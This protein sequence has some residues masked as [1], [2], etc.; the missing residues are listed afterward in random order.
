MSVDAAFLKSLHHDWPRHPS[1]DV[2]IR[3]DGAHVLYDRT[4]DA[5]VCIS[6]RRANIWALKVQ[7]HAAS[8]FFAYCRGKFDQRG[9]FVTSA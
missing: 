5:E 8:V 3:D 4:T 2:L 1:P 7:L 9:I 6:L